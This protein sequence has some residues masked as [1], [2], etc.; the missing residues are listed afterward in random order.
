MKRLCTF[1]LYEGPLAQMLCERLEQE[2]VGCIVKNSALGGA[3]GEIPFTECF[4]ELWLL[5][6]EVEPRARLLLKQWLELPAEEALWRCPRCGENLE[7]QF[8][9][10]WQCGQE[11]L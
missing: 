7:P 8:S 10:C 4:P 1:G 5:D 6:A 3:L 11:R 9:A 2:G